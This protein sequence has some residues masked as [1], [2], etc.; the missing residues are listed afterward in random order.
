MLLSYVGVRAMCCD[1]RPVGQDMEPTKSAQERR[2]SVT[3][4]YMCI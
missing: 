3:Y 2:A 4:K 1:L